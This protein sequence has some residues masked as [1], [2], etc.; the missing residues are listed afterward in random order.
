MSQK[1]VLLAALAT[2]KRVGDLQAFSVDDSCLEFGPGNP[3]VV[4]R[5]RPGYVPKVPTTPF[6]DQV[7]NLQA[8]PREEADPAIALLCPVRA[9]GACVCFGGQQKGR[10]VSQ[11]RLVHWIVEAIILAYQAPCLPCPLGVRAHSTRG[12]ASSWALARGA[13]IA[14]ICKA[15][16]WATPNTFARFYNL[17]IEPVSSRV[18]VSDGQ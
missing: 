12:V 6:R 18:L 7:V 17:R 11:Q 5:P 9:L 3:H 8:L 2:V 10:A 15:A 14:D 13:S 16:G 4:L 1:T